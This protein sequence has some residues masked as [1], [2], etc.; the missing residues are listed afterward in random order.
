MKEIQFNQFLSIEESAAE[1][2][3]G[4]KR[5]CDHRGAR[6]LPVQVGR[7][8]TIYSFPWQSLKILS[9]AVHGGTA[10]CCRLAW[11]LVPGKREMSGKFW[12]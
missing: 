1:K 6:S 3:K 8:S 9:G 4:K 11:L 5:G 10:A 7:Q 2:K 12:N